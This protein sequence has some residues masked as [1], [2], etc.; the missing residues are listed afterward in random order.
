MHVCN[1]VFH[2]SSQK[3]WLISVWICIFCG[4]FYGNVDLSYQPEKRLWFDCSGLALDS[5]PQ[6]PDL[7]TPWSCSWLSWFGWFLTT[8]FKINSTE[9]NASQLSCESPNH[10][11]EHRAS[12]GTGT[13][14]CTSLRWRRYQYLS[15]SLIMTRPT[16]KYMSTVNYQRPCLLNIRFLPLNSGQFSHAVSSV[17]VNVI[18]LFSR[19]RPWQAPLWAPLYLLCLSILP[20]TKI[21]L[22]LAPL[23]SFFFFF[24]FSPP[25]PPLTAVSAFHTWQMIARVKVFSVSILHFPKGEQKTGG[26][27]FC[28]WFHWENCSELPHSR[29][30]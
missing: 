26:Q 17:T 16:A 28:S 4:S 23:F 18:T 13:A 29:A 6:C 30:D 7:N 8:T 3:L 12:P 9:Q 19:W 14:G 21:P 11:C 1:N 10:P 27:A 15:L 5:T 20:A 24:L 2:F 22:S 25:S